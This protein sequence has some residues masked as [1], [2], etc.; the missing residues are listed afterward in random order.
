MTGTADVYIFG[1][2]SLLLTLLTL[3]ERREVLFSRP[4]SH[5]SYRV[6]VSGIRR[7]TPSDPRI[8]FVDVQ[9]P[10]LTEKV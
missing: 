8:S 4:S 1:A 6:R 7:T 3:V 2:V 10:R 9:G 5:S